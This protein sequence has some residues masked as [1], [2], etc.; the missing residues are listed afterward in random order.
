MDLDN[1]K[2]LFYWWIASAPIVALLLA[3]FGRKDVEPGAGRQLV[4]RAHVSRR[5]GRFRF[6]DQS[7]RVSGVPIATASRLPK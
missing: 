7:G 2:V 6:S 4:C 3:D 5:P 1:V